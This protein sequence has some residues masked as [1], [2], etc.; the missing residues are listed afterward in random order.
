MG[1]M[2]INGQVLGENRSNIAAKSY[3]FTL[4]TQKYNRKAISK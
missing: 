2:G 3:T 4:I 1:Y